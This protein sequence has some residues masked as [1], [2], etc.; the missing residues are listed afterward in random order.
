MTHNTKNYYIQ[1]NKDNSTFIFNVSS[2]TC[3]QDVIDDTLTPDIGDNTLQNGSW[4]CR[5]TGINPENYQHTIPL[6]WWYN[7]LTEK[8]AHKQFALDIADLEIELELEDTNSYYRYTN[9]FSGKRKTVKE[10]QKIVTALY[11]EYGNGE[12]RNWHDVLRYRLGCLVMDLEGDIENYHRMFKETGDSDY[13]NDLP[14]TWDIDTMHKEI[15]DVKK[16]LEK[17]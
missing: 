2:Y 3:L 14:N 1:I 6:T 5:Y 10:I 17:I 13:W 7:D 16:I 12:I 11:D 9:S 8:E 4:V 15:A